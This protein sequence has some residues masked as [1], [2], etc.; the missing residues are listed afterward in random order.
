VKHCT[1]AK[2]N[3]NLHSQNKQAS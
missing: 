1:A 2:T 3:Y